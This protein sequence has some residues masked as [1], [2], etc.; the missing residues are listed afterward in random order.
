MEIDKQSKLE[1]TVKELNDPKN[2]SFK[3][4]VEK[5]W[6]VFAAVGYWNIKEL[7][8]KKRPLS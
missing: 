6:K 3:S 1:E 2:G 5:A 7:L 8:R 4:R